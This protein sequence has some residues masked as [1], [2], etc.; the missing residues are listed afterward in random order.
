[1][2]GRSLKCK[3]LDRL[4]DFLEKNR[5]FNGVILLSE[6]GQT[7]YKRAVGKR[8]NLEQ[9]S[10]DSIF[11]VASISKSFTAMAVMILVEENKLKLDDDLKNFFRIFLTRTL[12]LKIC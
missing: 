3:E 1:M 6:K 12:Q 2:I 10:N 7:L 5:L 8:T 11:E 9:H 4:F